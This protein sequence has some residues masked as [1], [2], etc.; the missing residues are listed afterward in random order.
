MSKRKIQEKNFQYRKPKKKQK[1]SILSKSQTRLIVS[2][3]ILGVSKL[4]VKKQKPNENLLLS[5]LE[6]RSSEFSFALSQVFDQKETK[7]KEDL[8]SINSV[9]K[10][11]EKKLLTPIKNI[12]VD[13][14]VSNLINPKI[15]LPNQNE[16]GLDQAD[17]EK[18]EFCDGEHDIISCDNCGRCGCPDCISC[19][20]YCEDDTFNNTFESEYLCMDC[21]VEYENENKFCVVCQKLNPNDDSFLGEYCID[22][23]CHGCFKSFDC[24]KEFDEE[25]CTLCTELIPTFLRSL[26][27]LFIDGINLI[28]EYLDLPDY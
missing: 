26:T 17:L 6:L 4:M 24:K 7:T 5:N 23:H 11:Y 27:N 1:K 13:Q 16:V 14:E 12:K 25:Y 22:T 20:W 19:F 18:C 2:N 21:E 3:G 28:T 9:C 8:L 15:Q 10:T